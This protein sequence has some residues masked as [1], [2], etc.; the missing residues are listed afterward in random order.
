MKLVF[1]KVISIGIVAVLL[2]FVLSGCMEVESE[3]PIAVQ[4]V[5]AHS[6]IDTS[7]EYRYDLWS[8]GFKMMP[9]IETVW[10]ED[11]YKVQYEITYTNGSSY[12]AWRTVNKAIYDAISS[13]FNEVE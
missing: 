2:C 13:E 4:F 5:P 7:Y 3:K 12:T 1:R 6:E 10:Y 11:T 8:G 9:K